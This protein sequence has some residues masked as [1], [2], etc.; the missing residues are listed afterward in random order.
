MRSIGT[1]YG[2]DI[3]CRKGSA[4][5]GYS[6]YAT[7]KCFTSFAISLNCET[8]EEAEGLISDIYDSAKKNAITNLRKSDSGETK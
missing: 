5:D 6:F 2:I 1:N 4:E 7:D 8:K 3:V